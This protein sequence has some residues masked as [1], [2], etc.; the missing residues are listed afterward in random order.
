M[1]IESNELEAVW[2]DVVGFWDDVRVRHLLG[3]AEK[4][5]E[6]YQ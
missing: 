6:I 4:N 5:Y 1:N 2:K 3:G